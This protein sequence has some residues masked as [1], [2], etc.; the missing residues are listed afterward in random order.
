MQPAPALIEDSLRLARLRSTRLLDTF[1][2]ERFDRITRLARHFFNVPIC[3]VSLVDEDRQWFKSNTGLPDCQQT[4]R[5]ISFCGHAIAGREV[6]VV[7]DAKK[8]PRFCDNP[9]VTGSPFVRFYAG[10]PLQ[11]FDGFN[12]GTLCLIDHR[13]RKLSCQ[14]QR[15]LTDFGRLIE[16]EITSIHLATVD[17]LTGLYNR[18][19]FTN[20][21]EHLLPLCRRAGR[22]ATLLY[23][24]L[25][26]FK[27]IN[28]NF[29]H[30]AG[31]EALVSFAG[32]LSRA[33][34]ESDL[35]ARLAG[36]EFVV[37]LTHETGA[38]AAQRVIA[39]LQDLM[40]NFNATAG[41]RW[42][43]ACSIGEASFTPD[44]FSGLDS[45]LRRADEAMYRQKH[46]R[47]A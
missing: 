33:V 8:D 4:P 7:P 27:I 26:R 25:D 3:L 11:S 37:L 5:D 21:T 12:L 38:P 47:M 15:Y 32:L 2:D 20:L 13:P 30:S 46:H 6:M 14:Q 28:D 1:G 16:S 10:Y 41:H 40:T 22:S 44:S 31:D 17:S 42:Q 34:R 36:D 29:G 45:L 18:L 43:L 23:L 9:L 35:V 24:D 19:G 39:R